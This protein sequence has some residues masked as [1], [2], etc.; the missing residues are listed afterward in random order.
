MY[1]KN[2]HIPAC[3]FLKEVSQNLYPA[4]SDNSQVRLQVKRGGFWK[5][6]KDGGWM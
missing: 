6:P 1:K 3:P 5:A 2:P 4:S